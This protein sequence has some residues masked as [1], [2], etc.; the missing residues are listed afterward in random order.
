MGERARR[1]AADFSRERV[2][3]ELSE[4]WQRLG[5]GAPAA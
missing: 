3:G 1:R 5:E 4:L 2:L